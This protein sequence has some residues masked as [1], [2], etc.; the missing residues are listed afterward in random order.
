MPTFGFG[1]LPGGT[2]D[3]A[4]PADNRH[5]V[6]RRDRNVEVVEAVLDPLRQVLGADDVR[7]RLFGLARLVALGEDGDLDVLAEAVGKRDRAAQLLVR[8]ADVETGAYVHLDRLVELHARELLD[9]RH[10]LGGRVL[11][12]AVEALLGVVVCLSVCA[13]TPN[14][15]HAHRARGARDDLRGRVDVVGV[16][17][18]HLLLGDLA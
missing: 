11:A 4:E 1:I 13:M 16:Q 18:L 2:E 15:L 9:Q 8:V 3:P 17:V 6:G 14:D 5:Q 10:R 7:A 12:L